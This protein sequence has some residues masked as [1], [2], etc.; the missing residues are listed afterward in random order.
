MWLFHCKI[1]Q[2]RTCPL[3]GRSK[4]FWNQ[5]FFV[6]NF[7]FNFLKY[8]TSKGD[9]IIY[10]DVISLEINY[11]ETRFSNKTSEDKF[12]EDAK[13]SFIEKQDKIRRETLNS[14]FLGC[15]QNITD[16]NGGTFSKLSNQNLI[17]EVSAKDPGYEIIVIQIF[18]RANLTIEKNL[19]NATLEVL[20]NADQ[21]VNNKL[22]M[23]MNCMI[24]IILY[25]FLIYKKD[26]WLFWWYSFLW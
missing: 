25:N 3:R 2:Q 8:R 11:D 23:N 1:A 15:L 14:R 12:L 17:V 13:K 24:K 18:N 9:S 6:Y 4:D 5:L 10:T 21:K 19:A 26:R 22:K 20:G 16:P 7:L